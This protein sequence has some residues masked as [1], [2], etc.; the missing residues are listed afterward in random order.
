LLSA[1]YTTAKKENALFLV[2][3]SANPR[4]F[5]CANRNFHRGPLTFRIIFGE[6]DT[7]P[8][9]WD[10]EL[11]VSPNGKFCFS[12]A[13]VSFVGSDTE[14]EKTYYYIRVFQTD[15]ENPGGDPEV[16]WTSPCLWR[17]NEAR[18]GTAQTH[19]SPSKG[20]IG[21][22]AFREPVIFLKGC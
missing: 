13:L 19:L 17:T 7:V 2:A 15:T 21:S 6:S 22:I 10:G 4:G 3:S 1:S 14:P 8:T 5:C 16:A 18:A 12:P 20:Y 9:R 11:A